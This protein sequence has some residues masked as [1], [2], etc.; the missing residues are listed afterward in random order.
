MNEIIFYVLIYFIGG[1]PSAYVITKIFK[2]KDITKIGSG[3]IGTRNVFDNVSK[4][5]GI[6]TFILDFG[7]SLVAFFLYSYFKLSFL[8]SLLMLVL[9]HNFSPYLKLKGGKGLASS[10]T[11][12]ML[13]KPSLALISII[14]YLI[15][16]KI[17]KKTSLSTII[18]ITIILILINIF[19][20]NNIFL[21]LLI[22]IVLSIKWIRELKDSK[23]QN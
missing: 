10:M 8:G 6:I 1:F 17:V 14:T 22:W 4:Q 21:S 11:F 3:N 20:E 7:K 15:T 13:K 16:K 2:S 23:K 18:T 9:G 12:I 19:I 5:L